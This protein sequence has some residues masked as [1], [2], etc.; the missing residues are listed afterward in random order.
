MWRRIHRPLC[1][2]RPNAGGWKL[3][4]RCSQNLH[5][6]VR[7]LHVPHALRLHLRLHLC[8]LRV[9]HPR[10][11]PPPCLCPRLRLRGSA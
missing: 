5:L 8:V 10:P 4:T 6:R 9:L 7:V 3:M 11:R 2:P 1:P